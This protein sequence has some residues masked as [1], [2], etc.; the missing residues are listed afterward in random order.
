VGQQRLR[1]L[2]VLRAA[3]LFDAVHSS[4]EIQGLDHHCVAA[5]VG[6]EARLAFAETLSWPTC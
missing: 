4:Y 1:Q 5:T 2:D 3:W 6:L